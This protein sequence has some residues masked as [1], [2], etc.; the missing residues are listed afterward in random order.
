MEKLKKLYKG[1][2]C[3]VCEEEKEDGMYVYTAFVCWECERE[4]VQT[5]PGT[6]K[7]EQLVKKL[8]KIRKP[9]VFS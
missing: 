9:S 1:K 6:E 7:Y 5:E 4:I 2:T 8:G 3:V